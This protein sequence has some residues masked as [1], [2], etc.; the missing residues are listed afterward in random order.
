MIYVIVVKQKSPFM[1]R[2]H[3]REY[4]NYPKAFTLMTV[5]YFDSKED[6]DKFLA[7]ALLHSAYYQRLSAE[8]MLYVREIDQEIEHRKIIDL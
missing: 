4:P 3:R 5:G 1:N 2:R 7:N 6:A 8:H